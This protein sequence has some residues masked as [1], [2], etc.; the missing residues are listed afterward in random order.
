MAER[1]AGSVG[2]AGDRRLHRRHWGEKSLWTGP[3]GFGE[4]SKPRTSAAAIGLDMAL[5][6]IVIPT[7]NRGQSLKTAVESL[8]SS[9]S[10][11]A[12][13]GD[14]EICIFDNQSVD[15]TPHVSERIVNAHQIVSYRRH[16]KEATSAE[17]SAYL[18]LLQL[19]REGKS[20]Y[21]W[22]F[23]DDDAVHP[24]A[25]GAVYEALLAGYDFVLAN[26][27]VSRPK[28]EP[29][30]YYDIT[31]GGVGYSDG[32]QLFLDFGLVTATTT[33]SCLAGRL[34]AI[35]FEHWSR[36]LSISAIY[37]HSFTF[38]RSFS[39]RK[40]AALGNAV[41]LYNFNTVDDELRRLKRGGLTSGRPLFWPYT[42]GL[43]GLVEESFTHPGYRAAPAV[44]LVEEIHLSKDTFHVLHGTLLGFLF[45]MFVAQA[46]LYVRSGDQQEMLTPRTVER[47]L[48]LVRTV[49]DREQ[50]ESGVYLCE[51]LRDLR[52]RNGADMRQLLRLRVACNQIQENIMR[53]RAG[54]RSAVFLETRGGIP[55]KP[56]RGE[57]LRGVLR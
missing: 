6:T 19:S 49:D 5:L 56:L 12:A 30:P 16:P 28:K 44:E 43:L 20:T 26:L 51:G 8:L 32:R 55:V 13:D 29:I 22:L 18:S 14:I 41:V 4:I 52:A 53:K 46:H 15:D 33:L 36:L 3:V 35:D 24:E 57:P 11:S 23:G 17:E 48:S 45:D 42:E 27:K 38:L 1:W 7:R 2:V 34:S 9:I 37:S 54:R 21:F 25:C 10:H 40:A 50:R 39:N 47:L 31:S